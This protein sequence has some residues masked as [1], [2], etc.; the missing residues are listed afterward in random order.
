MPEQ[1]FSWSHAR[2]SMNRRFK[3]Y[4]DIINGI[5]NFIISYRYCKDKTIAFITLVINHVHFSSQEVL[6]LLEKML[7]RPTLSQDLSQSFNSLKVCDFNSSGQSSGRLH[8]KKRQ[9]PIIHLYSHTS[10]SSSFYKTTIPKYNSDPHHKN[11]S[12]PRSTILHN[13]QIT[14]ITWNIFW[15]DLD[16]FEVNNP[17]HQLTI[18]YFCIYTCIYKS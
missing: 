9:E 18:T 4:L 6:Q 1:E 13:K 3:W 14:V 16:S 11:R 17:F 12:E 7:H 15:T 2:L 8:R 10:P 5:F